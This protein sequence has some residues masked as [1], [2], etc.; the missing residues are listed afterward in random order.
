MPDETLGRL[1]KVD[2][3]DVWTKE[4]SEFTSWL[5]T[6]LNELH[7]VFANRVRALNVDDWRPSD[8][9]EEPPED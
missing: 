8:D 4:A 3:R 1:E 5:V 6:R 9:E 2:L 7:R